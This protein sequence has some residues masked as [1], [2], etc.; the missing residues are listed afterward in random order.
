[1]RQ[2]RYF[3]PVVLNSFPNKCYHFHYK[4][5]PLDYKRDKSVWHR[6][7]NT[8]YWGRGARHINLPFS[9]SYCQGAFGFVHEM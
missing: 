2:D 9:S 4:K 6:I 8:K 3:Y 1:V 7:L 5:Y